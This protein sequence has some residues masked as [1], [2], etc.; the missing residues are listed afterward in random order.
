MRLNILLLAINLGTVS[1]ATSQHKSFL[2]RRSFAF[3]R[4]A[5]VKDLVKGMYERGRELT[6]QYLLRSHNLLKQHHQLDALASLADPSKPSRP[7]SREPHCAPD[8]SPDLVAALAF[9]AAAA[10]AVDA[11]AS[12][13]LAAELRGS[14]AEEV[15]RPFLDRVM[16]APIINRDGRRQFCFDASI[17]LGIFDGGVGVGG[18]RPEGAASMLRSALVVL[19]MPEEG[20]ASLKDVIADVREGGG[21]TEELQAASMLEAKGVNLPLETFLGLCNKIG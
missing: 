8:P 1:D 13:E 7:Q 6:H 17:M 20:L 11:F 10:A 2:A 5:L 4:G 9:Y 18:G 21:E 3:L 15:S 16:D 12:A 19:S 14:L